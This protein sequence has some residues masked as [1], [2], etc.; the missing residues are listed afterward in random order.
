M[1]HT[2]NNINTNPLVSFIVLTYNQAQFVTETLSGALSQD[3]EN[4][5]I[6]VSDDASEDNTY[7]VIQQYV[8]EHPSNKKVIINRNKKNMGLVPHFNYVINQLTHGEILVLA[9]GDDISLPNRVTDSVEVFIE[10][11]SIV[12][13]TG[14]ALI[15]D[16]NSEVTGIFNGAEP[17][18]YTLDDAYIKSTSFMSGGRGP[19]YRKE[20]VWNRFG[21]LHPLCPTEDS[22]L[23]LRTL[24]CGQII[25][26]DK[27]FIKYRIHGNNMSLGQNMYK[28][29]TKEIARQYLR[30]LN[31]AQELSL[32]PIEQIKRIRKKVRLYYYDRQLSYLQSKVENRY[33]WYPFKIMQK[34]IK[35][36]AKKI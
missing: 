21:E 11:P 9:G 7:E 6:I 35:G 20:M 22:T 15:I 1:K 3:Y 33:V 19:A 17:G 4:L 24:L 14:Q 2:G 16:K 26:L 12:A 23:R 5:E 36:I 30:D 25:V 13:V 8:T 27:Y 28:L 18:V 34:V 32:Q 10:N 31:V 29:K